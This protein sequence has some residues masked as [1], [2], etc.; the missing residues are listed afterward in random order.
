[1]L[2]LSVS[3]ISLF[4]AVFVL[5]Y[6]IPDRFRNPLLLLASV[7]FVGYA[8]WMFLAVAALITAFT[9]GAARLIERS[10][11]KRMGWLLLGSIGIL[12]ATWISFRYA[13]SLIFPLGISFYTFQ[14]IG[15]LT[16]VYWGE[17][18]AERNV[19]RFSLFM[20]FFMKFLSGPI[21]RGGDMFSQLREPKRFDYDTTVSGLKLIFLGLF[22]KLLIANHIAPYTAG[23][24]DT[25]AELEGIQLVVA[26][27]L[28]PIELYAD[29]SGYTDIALGGARMFGIH[30]TANFNRPFTA[31]ST[32]DLWRRWHI[33]LSSWVRDYVY[34]PL[35]AQLRGWGL[36]G[37]LTSLIVTFVAL[38]VWHGAGWT[39]AVYGLI[40]GLIICYE[41]KFKF[42]RNLIYKIAGQG[43]GDAVHILRTYLLFAFSLIFFRVA[44]MSDALHYVANLSL[45]AHGNWK[46]VNIGMPDH[47]WAVAGASIIVLWIYEWVAAHYDVGGKFHRLPAAVRWICYFTL[48]FIIFLLGK[49]DTE[50][51]I[52]IQF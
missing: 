36:W 12:V 7:V 41:L 24:F 28:Y 6:L 14:A 3:F 38:G 49:F 35:T 39:F 11:E 37:V 42:I 31:T 20:L 13:T 23:I 1:M 48:V 5:Y 30:L 52:Y 19:V 51:F 8:N 17:T 16:D 50:N 29:F 27:L 10:N 43:I 21:E 2:F 26:A 18:K 34:V 33:S 40:Q 15:Y 4:I 9:Y 46:E 45:N 32:T 22:K 25:S 47:N 44:T